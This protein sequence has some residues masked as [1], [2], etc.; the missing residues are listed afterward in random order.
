MMNDATTLGPISQAEAA[1]LLGWWL[2]AGVYAAV[3][4][5]PRDWLRQAAPPIAVPAGVAPAGGQA[6]TLD[7]FHAWIETASGMPLDRPGARRVPPKGIEAA[8]IMLV[9]DLPGP[10]EAAAGQ[11]IAGEAWVLA[12]RMLAAIGFTV[13]QAYVA[14]LSCFHAPGARL[15]REE[16]E[17]CGEIAREQLRLARPERLMLFGD[18]PSRALLGQPLSE[19]RGK[20]HRVNGVRTIATFHPRFL[21]KRPS[22]K[23]LAWKDLLLLMSEEG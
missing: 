14:S 7:A 20:I 1:S 4:E 3:S 18:A 21:L 12:T 9:S 2:D 11:P 13:E 22:D 6:A 5:T 19:A 8:P 10:E 15:A 16:L 23:A 17:R